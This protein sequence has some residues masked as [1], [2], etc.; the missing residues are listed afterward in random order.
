LEKNKKDDNMI[1]VP[2]RVGEIKP[3]RRSFGPVPIRM[4]PGIV[5]TE[6][7]YNEVAVRQNVPVSG[8]LSKW[9]GQGNGSVNEQPLFRGVTGGSITRPGVLL[10]HPA[11]KT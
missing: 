6:D 5:P 1:E 4:F 9:G 10:D 7:I 8:V 11:R 3:M 2:E